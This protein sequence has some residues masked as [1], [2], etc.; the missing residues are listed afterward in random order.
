MIS[1][2][3]SLRYYEALKKEFEPRYIKEIDGKIIDEERWYYKYYFPKRSIILD[4]IKEI[5]RELVLKVHLDIH[6]ND[7]DAKMHL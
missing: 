7:K 4:S 1:L 6:N 3:V 5:Y 2:N